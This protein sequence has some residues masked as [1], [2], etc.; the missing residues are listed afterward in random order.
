MKNISN[1][2]ILESVPEYLQ[3]IIAIII[4]IALITLTFE[5]F[6]T[7]QESNQIQISGSTDDMARLFA[8]QIQTCWKNH[9]YGLDPQSDVC[10]IISINSNSSFSEKNVVKYIDCS[11]LPD[12]ICSPDDCRT[13]ISDKFSDEDKIKWNL[14][15][16][17]ANVSIEYSGDKRAIFVN[18]LS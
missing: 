14:N 2:G 6:R 8:D 16:F 5:F 7:V 11:T 18:S 3:V 9:R 4:G 13:C 10:K 17:P 12:N 1:K 15:V